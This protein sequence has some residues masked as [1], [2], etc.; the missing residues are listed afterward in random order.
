MSAVYCNET[1]KLLSGGWNSN[2]LG[3]GLFSLK[4]GIDLSSTASST[5]VISS[6]STSTISTATHTLALEQASVSSVHEHSTWETALLSHQGSSR[7]SAAGTTLSPSKT[8]WKT[9]V[10]TAASSFNTATGTMGSILGTGLILGGTGL[11]CSGNSATASSLCSSEN[12]HN[13]TTW[14][15]PKGPMTLAPKLSQDSSQ[16]SPKLQQTTV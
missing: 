10:T 2:D 8:S 13:R 14:T 7:P 3:E 16:P 5:L 6:T 9:H 11:Y 15:L 4:F 1:D 12:F